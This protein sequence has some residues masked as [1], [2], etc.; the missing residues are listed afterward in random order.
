LQRHG[1]DFAY[2]NWR[3]NQRYDAEI[4][5]VLE[6]TSTQRKPPNDKTPGLGRGHLHIICG[7]RV[8]EGQNTKWPNTIRMEI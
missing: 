8:S 3:N 4:A 5:W 2:Q 7:Y 1:K 6:L